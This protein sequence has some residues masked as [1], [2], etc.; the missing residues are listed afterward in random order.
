MKFF[1]LLL[2]NFGS[3]QL[4]AQSDSHKFTNAKDYQTTNFLD[5][6]PLHIGNFWQFK[7][8]YVSGFYPS[9]TIVYYANREVLKDTLMPNGKV[10]LEVSDTRDYTF[11]FNNFLRIDSSTGCIYD[12][13]YYNNEEYLID[14]LKMT[15]GDMIFTGNEYWLTC[16]NVDSVNLFGELRQRKH[17]SVIVIPYEFDYKY[18]EGIGEIYRFN[19]YEFIVAEHY[20][21][22]ITYAMINGQEY[23]QLVSVN[24]NIIEEISY[25]LYQ[26][27]PNPFNPTTKI[28]YSIP[29]IVNGQVSSVTLKVYDVLGNEIATL[30]NEEKPAGEY[31]VEINAAGL[32]SGIYFYQ[33]KAGSFFQ[34]KK[35][36]YLK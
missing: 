10:Y 11:Y 3:L 33:L 35:M 5:L 24:D 20:L 22:E 14:S 18:A 30:V 12:Y 27:Y 4:F 7:V 26:N 19:R 1:F 31:E 17:F 28:K 21:S 29:S 2:I 34:T 36:V 15:E 25:K 9:D 8:S 23:G 32:P 6:F 16:T 13:S